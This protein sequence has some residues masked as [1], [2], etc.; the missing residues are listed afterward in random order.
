MNPTTAAHDAIYAHAKFKADQTAYL[1]SN[2]N[3]DRALYCLDTRNPIRLTCQRLVAPSVGHRQSGRQPRAD[4][5]YAISALTYASIV[6]V[7]LIACVTTP[8]YQRRYIALHGSLKNAWFL[9]ADV[10]FASFFTFEAVVKIIADGF[11]STP[12]AYFKNLWNKIDLFVLVSLWINVI[13]EFTGL[14]GLG[15]ASRAFKALRA[16][17]LVNI[18]STARD[19]FHHVI[20]SGFWNILGAAVVSISLLIPFAIW[21]LNIFNGTMYTCNDSS[22]AVANIT[23]C[24]NEYSS[25]PFQWDVWAPR[26]WDHVAYWSFDTFGGSLLLLFEIVSQEGWI[27]VMEAAMA[28][29]GRDQ[30]PQDYSTPGNALFFVAF[31]LLGAVFVLQLFVSIIIRN[32]TEKSGG[33]FLTSEQRSW[34][35]LKK[36]LYQMHP[37]RRPM[38]PCSKSW[39]AWCYERA[40]SKKGGWSRFITAV[41]LI[42]IFLLMAEFYPSS[43]A[44]DKVRDLAFLF[45][46]VIYLA[47]IVVRITGLGYRNYFSSRWNIFDCI[48]I[49]GTAITTSVTL[50]GLNQGLLG[51]FQKLFLVLVVLNL[52]AKVDSLDQ[53]FKTAA[54]SLPAIANLLLTWLVFYVMYAIAFN[55]IFGLTRTGKYSMGQVNFRTMSNALVLLFRMSA[56]EGWNAIMHDFTVEEPYCVGSDNFF[57]SDCGSAPWAFTLFISWNIISMYIFVN[58]LVTVVYDSFSYV[59]QKTGKLSNVTRTEL[60]RFKKS[61]RKFDPNGTGFIQ[62]ADAGRFLG[63]LRGA[64]DV[65]IYDEQYSVPKLVQECKTLRF[66]TS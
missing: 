57:L 15:R 37:S 16:L 47:N 61:W 3:F 24:V 43:Y 14:G 33:A 36:I 42:H 1:T 21:G 62:G 25:S 60:R 59:Y 10:A 28:I 58:M 8:F 4:L 22:N 63:T 55:Q 2:P 17:R 46:V 66:S 45:L 32:Y 19:T 39:K 56:G 35:E 9:W 27:D 26:S 29:T 54:A 5:W 51:Q 11:Y 41:Y 40:V 53:L 18:S 38:E 23:Q 64:F 13:A 20:I 44:Y 48:T 50:F 7:V 49:F 34:R 31:N 6:A 12:N 52:I 30:A 65:R